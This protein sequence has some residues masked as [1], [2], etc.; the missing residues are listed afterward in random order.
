MARVLVRGIY[1]FLVRTTILKKNFFFFFNLKELD[2]RLFKHIL[3][4]K[5]SEKVPYKPNDF[6]VTRST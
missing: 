2:L 3:P 5:E 1:R 6:S 4:N